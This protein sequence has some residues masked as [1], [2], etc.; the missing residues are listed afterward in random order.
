VVKDRKRK[1]KGYGEL[2]VE[3]RVGKESKRKRKGYGEVV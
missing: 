2:R 1:R 3:L